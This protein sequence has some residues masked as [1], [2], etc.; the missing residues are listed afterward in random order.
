MSIKL[1]SIRINQNRKPII[2]GLTFDVLD[3]EILFLNNDDDVDRAI[4]NVISGMEKVSSGSVTISGYDIGS[5]KG[6]E[7]TKF[8]RNTV[9]YLRGYFL[10]SNLNVRDNIALPGMISGMAKKEMRSRIDSIAK[11]FEI[12]EIL[13]KKPAKISSEQKEKICVARTLFM[14]P[15]IILAIEPSEYAIQVFSDYV[16]DK[17]AIFIITSNNSDLESLATRTLKIADGKVVE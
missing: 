16:K 7:R 10:Q 6:L 11:K 2:S 4:L 12:S 3:G 8:F 17:N 15:K 9:S 1:R 13:K 5:M 14:N